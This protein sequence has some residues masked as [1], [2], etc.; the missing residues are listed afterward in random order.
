MFKTKDPSFSEIYFYV[1]KVSRKEHKLGIPLLFDINL[2]MSFLKLH[3]KP[4]YEKFL[5]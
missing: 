3:A 4:P 2:Q 1:L 5:Y